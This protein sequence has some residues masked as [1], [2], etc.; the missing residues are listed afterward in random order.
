MSLSTC[1]SCLCCFQCRH[2]RGADALQRV[3]R[4]L[5]V[6][7]SWVQASREPLRPLCFDYKQSTRRSVEGIKAATLQL[8]HQRGCMRPRSVTQ[9]HWGAAG[10]RD[11][12]MHRHP[13]C[14]STEPH[15]RR[16]FRDALQPAAC[17]EL[18]VASQLL[19]ATCRTATFKHP[20]G[21]CW[22]RNSSAVAQLVAA[23]PFCRLLPFCRNDRAPQCRSGTASCTCQASTPACT[24]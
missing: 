21:M 19:L 3:H 4:H 11:A 18:A 16:Y 5:Q 9:R 15:A 8:Q 23:V 10:V 6:V 24:T 14:S 20:A 7:L 22:Q 12:S 2:H 17:Q 13:P 1:K